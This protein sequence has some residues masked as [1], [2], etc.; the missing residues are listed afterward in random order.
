MS[1]PHWVLLDGKRAIQRGWQHKV[2]S[3]EVIH[4]HRDSGLALG[5]V[6]GSLSALVIDVDDFDAVPGPPDLGEPVITYPS[7]KGLHH[8][9]KVPNGTMPLDGRIGPWGDIKHARGYVVWR[10]SPADMYALMEL[11]AL[12]MP[13]D[14]FPLMRH[15]PDPKITG[16]P[17]DRE[18]ST[19]LADVRQLLEQVDPDCPEP[20]WRAVAAAIHSEFPG[21]D[22]YELFD[23]WSARGHKYKGSRETASK[24]RRL[25]QT[26]GI[27]MGTLRYMA[28]GRD[29]ALR[30]PG[31]LVR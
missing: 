24:W 17:G 6:P 13:I 28:T 3:R 5:V 8:W 26:G 1:R 19:T 11:L 18:R 16:H 15:R 25:D 30:R 9:H 10:Q 21:Q 29:T 12:A 31:G 4:A 20:E 2:P 27:T 7:P 22:G 14:T 23:S